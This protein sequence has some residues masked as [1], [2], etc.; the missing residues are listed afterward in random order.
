MKQYIQKVEAVQLTPDNINQIA[1]WLGDKG[2]IK[3][4]TQGP[5][6]LLES[7]HN[8]ES[9]GM[10]SWIIKDDTGLFTGSSNI[11]FDKLY[12]PIDPEVLTVADYEAVL[13]DHRRLVREIDVI[14]FGDGAAKQASLCDMVNPIRKLVSEYTLLKQKYDNILATED[15]HLNQTENVWQSGYAAGHDAGY[16]KGKNILEPQANSATVNAEY[17]GTFNSFQQWVN[18]ASAALSGH[19]KGTVICIDKAGN[20]CHIGEDFMAA[21]DHDLFPVKAYRMKKT[22]E[23]V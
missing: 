7:G 15:G 16:E 4:D 11:Y 22:I 21:R 5:Y 6:I 12:T 20:L 14:M 17:L 10:G 3:E 18:H 9:I 8:Y 2:E 1:E 19:P 13:A 23:S